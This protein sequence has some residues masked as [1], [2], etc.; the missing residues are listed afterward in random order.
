M[1][2]KAAHDLENCAGG[3]FSTNH[4]G[5]KS[6]CTPLVFPVG[7]E[8]QGNACNIVG[9]YQGRCELIAREIHAL[10]LND[11]VKCRKDSK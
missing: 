9:K 11:L 4:K 7:A 10:A 5:Q 8:H 3:N 2:G 1:H 6:K